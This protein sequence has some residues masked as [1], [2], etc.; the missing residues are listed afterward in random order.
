MSLK[1]KI[2]ER[3]KAKYNATGVNLS[4]KRQEDI[5]SRLDS[6]ITEEDQIDAKLDELNEIFPF[7][8]I[9]KEDDRIVGLE[10][11]AEKAKPEPQPKPTPKDEPKP[12][13]DPPADP[14]DAVMQ[15][16]KEMRAELGSLK[17]DKIVKSRI[18]TAKERFKNV[19]KELQEDL[20]TDISER[21]FQSDEEYEGFLARKEKAIAFAV[22]TEHDGKFGKDKP[23][24]GV[25]GNGSNSKKAS[26]SELDAVLG[27]LEN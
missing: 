1:A 8:D 14:N 26:E 25:G 13:P 27:K 11:A 19:P 17:A 3:L 7:A 9:A 23:F 10:K 4:K 20:L 18:E 12:E 22:K 5:A 6:K 24:G 16:L 21:N 15:M 2:I